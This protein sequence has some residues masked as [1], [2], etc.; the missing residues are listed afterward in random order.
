MRKHL[1]VLALFFAAGAAGVDASAQEFTGSIYGR[2]VDQTNMLLPGVSITVEGDAIQG[3]RTAVSEG[4]GSYRFLNLPQG[5]YKVTFQKAKFKT[6][7][8]EGAKVEVNKT[9]TMNVTM[10]IADVEETLV[11]RGSPIVDVKNATVGTNFGASMLSDIPH[12]RDL[13]ALL[14]QTP[15]ITMPRMDIGGNTAGTQSAYRAY[16]LSGQTITT[17]DGVNV[18]QGFNSEAVGAYLDFGALS[19]VQISAAG[20]A[21]DVA[22]AGAAITTVIKSGSN[23]T[24]GEGFADVKP[25][26]SKRYDGTETYV[27]YRDI[28]GQLGGPFIQDR[29]W[30][31]TSFRDQYN[32]FSTGMYDKPKEQGGK[33]GQPFI[34]GTTNFTVKLN[35]QLGRKGTLT[36]M[37]QLG[38]KY[39]PYRF[40]DGAGAFLYLVESTA[41]QRSWSHIGKVDYTRVLSSRATLDTSINVYGTH[42]PLKAHTDKTPIFDDYTRSRMGAY[43]NPTLQQDRR[44]HYNTNLNLYAGRHDLKIGYMFQWYAP[45]DT[46]YGA[47]GPAGTAGHVTIYTTDGV[48]TSF[49]TDNGPVWNVNTLKNHALFVQ[50]K[51]SL[52]SKLTLNYGLRFDQYHSAYPEQRFGLNDN[53][54]CDDDSDCDLG[55]YTVRTTTPARDVVTFNTLVPRIALIYDVFGNSKTALKASWGRF[56]TNPAELISSLVNPIDLITKKYAWNT[57][58]LTADP[59][60]AATRITPAY[61][62]TLQPIFGGAQLTPSIVDP[63]LKDSHTDEFTFGAEQEIISDLRGYVTF[64]RK[65]QK[66]TFG[67]YDRLRT[68]ANY[69]PVEALDPGPDGVAGG[70][71]KEDDRIITVFETGVPP[72]TTDYYLTNKPI[73]DTYDSVEFGAVKRMRDN[74][75]LISGFTWTKR[76]LSSL[77]SEDP[78]IVAWNGTNTQTTGWTFK[79]SGSYLW[80]WGVLVGFTYNARKG[81]AYGRTFTVTDQYLTLADPKRT[82]PLAQ[83]NQTLIVEKPGTYYLPSPHLVSVLAQKAFAIKDSLRLHVMFSVFNIAGNDTVTGVN[84]NTSQSFGYPTA[85]MGK[86]VVRFSTRFTF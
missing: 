26:S 58:D 33:D 12:Q 20:N 61:V 69:T 66:N 79:A 46:E 19:G 35:Y 28:N 1:L 78:N 82:T 68:I 74:W 62:A 45:R 3:Q 55:P 2:I 22:V 36:F 67:R 30:Y 37:T 73:G 84:T 63:N 9:V 44:R 32:E 31:F 75:Q 11:V 57:S 80:R 38:R 8:Y 14:A 65:A 25:A 17:V 48:P 83:G 7:V 41:H 54:P 40:G 27:L 42:F 13:F 34:T 15:G 24:H 18:T 56:S 59:A 16:G 5:A 4:T 85:R 49:W 39:Q 60:V 52:T 51:F 47:P 43:P 72:D 64:V 6:I 53:K 86:T 71:N 50:D 29:F 81:E 76:K 10:R 21:A 77:F 23:R 70:T